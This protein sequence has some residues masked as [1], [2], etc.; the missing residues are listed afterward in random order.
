[1]AA[2]N[3]T[4]TVHDI[5]SDGVDR[6]LIQPIV[7]TMGWETALN[8]RSTTWRGLLEADKSDLDNIKA[9]ELILA[10]PTLMKRPVFVSGSSVVCGFDAKAQDQLKNMI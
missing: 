3:V 6:S 8:R 7:E 1:M 4:H 9:V 10:N 2:E 5:R